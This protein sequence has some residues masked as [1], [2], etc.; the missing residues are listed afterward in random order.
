ML[1]VFLLY[2][3]TFWAAIGAVL[4]IRPD[5]LAGYAGVYADGAVA[6]AELRAMYGGLEL[7][8]AAVT[9]AAC[10]RRDWQRSVLFLQVVVCAG[11]GAGRLLGLAVDGAAAA[12]TFSALAFE[13]TTVV[14]A[15]GFLRRLDEE[16]RGG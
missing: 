14:I 1:R 15:L 3:A 16:C 9:A 8:I 2:L 13:L 5:L 11:I 12:Y 10:W 7:A 4:L 6:T